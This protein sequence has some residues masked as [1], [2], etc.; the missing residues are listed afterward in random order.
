MALEGAKRHRVRLGTRQGRSVGE[1]VAEKQGEGA[2]RGARL[3]RDVRSYTRD[4]R[5]RG[6]A[7]WGVACCR[8]MG[9]GGRGR[10]T[11]FPP[12]AAA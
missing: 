4:V 10:A 6:R 1:G 12:R 2:K 5:G 7:A 11:P 8:L 9:I 3:C